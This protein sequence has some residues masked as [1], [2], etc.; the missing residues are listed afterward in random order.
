MGDAPSQRAQSFVAERLFALTRDAQNSSPSEST[1]Q[2]SFR[3][4]RA[5]RRTHGFM[6]PTRVH[7]RPVCARAFLA[8]TSCEP[9]PKASRSAEGQTPL[10]PHGDLPTPGLRL[11]GHLC[12]SEELRSRLE[13]F[14]DASKMCAGRAHAV[15]SG[16]LAHPGLQVL[17]RCGPTRLHT[18]RRGRALSDSRR[19]LSL[20]D[21]TR[22]GAGAR[23]ARE[24]PSSSAL[25]HCREQALSLRA[26]LHALADLRR[27]RAELACLAWISLSGA[28]RYASGERSQSARSR[29][30]PEKRRSLRYLRALCDM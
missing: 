3:S 12:A 25:L 20:S 15:T 10:S 8:A 4:S 16:A 11:L 19:G 30:D 13:R 14:R 21:S 7:G 18:N 1:P 22:T 26:P 17:L 6:G 9:A 23:H 27:E 24:V 5:R 28:R 2:L 29:R